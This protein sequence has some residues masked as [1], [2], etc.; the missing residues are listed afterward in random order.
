MSTVVDTVCWF[1]KKESKKKEDLSSVAVK[2]SAAQTM[3][4]AC[5]ILTSNQRKRLQIVLLFSQSQRSG[6]SAPVLKFKDYN[7]NI[8]LIAR[9]GMGS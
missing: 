7:R 8:R 3:E 9:A 6:T 2:I 5:R 1:N 4:Y